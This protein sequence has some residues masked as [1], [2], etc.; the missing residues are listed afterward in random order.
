ME[1]R[2]QTASGILTVRRP[3]PEAVGPLQMDLPAFSSSAQDV[4]QEWQSP[5]S[6]LIQVGSTSI[7]ASDAML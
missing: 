4:P 2:F 6:E 5:D 1:L 3:S 7:N